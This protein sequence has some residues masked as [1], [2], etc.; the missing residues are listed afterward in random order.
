MAKI[1]PGFYRRLRVRSTG[2]RDLGVQIKLERNPSGAGFRGC[3]RVKSK[4]AL[5]SFNAPKGYY[6]CA[7]GSNPRKATAAALRALAKKLGKRKGAFAGL[8]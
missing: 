6:I 7:V 3:A 4:I 8:K 2:V 5:H 1:K